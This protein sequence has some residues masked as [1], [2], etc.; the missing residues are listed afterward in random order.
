MRTDIQIF[1]S[2][3]FGEIRTTGTSEQPLFCL[4]D[5]CRILG[6]KQFRAN[7]RLTNDVISNHPIVDSL[8]RKQ[9]AIFINE[10]GLYD[11]IFDSRKPEA[12]AFRKWV[13][14]EVLPQI[15]KTGG[16]ISISE[17]D[18]EKIILAK[19][20]LIYERTLEAQ[21]KRAEYEA[22]RAEQLEKQNQ[23]L[24]LDGEAKDK[25]I[26]SLLPAATFAHAV[27]TSDKS[28]LIGE[29]AKI[30]CQ[31]GVSIGQNRMFTWLRENGYLC[32]KGEAYNLPTQKAMNMGLFEVKKTSII[33]PDGSTLVTSTSKVTG[34]G[35]IYF[36]NKFLA[37]MVSEHNAQPD[38]HAEFSVAHT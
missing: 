16:Y 12:R 14:S 29:L 37:D 11:V 10:D 30:I 33:K 17:D 38:F 15:R 4:T 3:R 20:V 23:R 7:E 18:D 5:V 6:L 22:A 9:T 21:K 36:V 1:N 19:A 35:Q 25:H 26:Q 31:N 8:G 24:E 34:K 28:I 27:K 13:T 32:I 2:P